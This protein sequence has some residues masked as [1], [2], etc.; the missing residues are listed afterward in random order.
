MDRRKG[1]KKKEKGA[2]S[3]AAA[4]R[5]KVE[6]GEED[7]VVGDETTPR[8][9]KRVAGS[10]SVLSDVS[11]EAHMHRGQVATTRMDGETASPASWGAL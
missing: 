2:Q 3:A 8:V 5:A 6:E 9:K 1:K 11:S 4:K 7:G 10:C